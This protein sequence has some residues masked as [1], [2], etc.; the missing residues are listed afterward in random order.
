V[1]VVLRPPALVRCKP[2]V[3]FSEDGQT[4][5]NDPKRTSAI[6]RHFCKN[7][8]NQHWRQLQEAF[9]EFLADGKE[10]AEISL[11]GPEKLVLAGRLLRLTAA[12]K[13][14]DDFKF[15]EEPDDPVEPDDDE[16]DDR[17]YPES[18]EL[19]SRLDHMSANRCSVWSE[20]PRFAAEC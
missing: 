20:A 2:Y 3:C 1:N 6:R 10:A 17:D 7:W 18:S 14:P 16:A 8:W 19:G 4:A 9:C 5:I 15:V 11:E 13:M 12:R